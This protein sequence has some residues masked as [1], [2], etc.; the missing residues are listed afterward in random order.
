MAWLEEGNKEIKG[1]TGKKEVEDEIAVAEGR[2]SEPN[3][4]TLWSST[5]A[6][7]TTKCILSYIFFIH[8]YLQSIIITGNI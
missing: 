6:G 3:Q 1:D 7:A 2:E 5:S 4:C 8:V